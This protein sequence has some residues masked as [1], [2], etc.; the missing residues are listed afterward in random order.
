MMPRIHML[1]PLTLVRGFWDDV[2]SQA[3]NFITSS[4]TFYLQADDGKVVI[5]QVTLSA[6]QLQLNNCCT[7][8]LKKRW[9]FNFVLFLLTD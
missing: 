1:Y 2:M 8:G 4:W 7:L 6:K 9:Y 5:F 3:H